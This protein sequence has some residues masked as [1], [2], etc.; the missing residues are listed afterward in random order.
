MTLP[1]LGFV[2]LRHVNS[3]ITDLYWK[4]SYASLRRLYPTEPIV[5][6]DDSSQKIW[7]REDIVLTHTTVIYDTE[8][9]G[10]A[11]L[12]PYYYALRL[13]PARR[14]VILHDSVFLHQRLDMS[15]WSETTGIQYLWDIPHCYDDAIQKEIHALIDALPEGEGERERIRQMY[16]HKKE[17]W[18]GLFGVMSIIDIEWLGEIERRWE[19]LFERWFPLLTSR[20]YRCGLERVL[21]LLASYHGRD[22]IQTPLLGRIGES[23]PWG[24]S[25][26][27]YLTGYEKYRTQQR[28][29]KV[30]SG[31]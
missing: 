28:V 16:L 5:I 23:L 25:F 4:E 13:R 15:S 26:L 27:Q 31:R 6:V 11:E 30:W 14:V 22:R 18:T 8:H 3:K 2:I 9:R 7:L 24:T 19:G 10:C 1:P 17:E 20:E 21:G 29:M 12:L